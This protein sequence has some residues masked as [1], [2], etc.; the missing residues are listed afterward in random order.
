[1]KDTQNI[2]YSYFAAQKD[3]LTEQEKRQIK[4]HE[5][6]LIGMKTIPVRFTKYQF[7]T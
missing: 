5:E 3:M 6:Y 1:M 7:S 4:E 2:R